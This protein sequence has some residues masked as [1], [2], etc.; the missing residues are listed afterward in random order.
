MTSLPPFLLNDGTTLPAVGFGTWRVRGDEAVAQVRSA[1]DA[2]YRLIDTAAS[3]GNEAEVGRAVTGTDVPRSEIA[4]A[5]KLRGADQGYDATLRGFEATRTALGL[6]YLDLYLIHWPLPR[7]GKFVESW[8]ALVRLR[9]DGLIR[10]VG[11]SNFT[12]AHLDRLIDETGEVPAVNQIE[13]HPGFVQEDMRAANADRGILTQSWG[14][15]GRGKGLLERPEIARIAAARGVSPAQA[16]LRWHH[17]LGVQPLPKSAD[18]ARQQENLDLTGF[19][20]TDEEMARIASVPQERLGG[21]PDT[22]EE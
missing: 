3:Y 12:A 5:S 15:L 4:V 11:V 9:E 10:T 22:H 8:K 16:V 1:L 14:P 19:S 18:P 21:D 13:L 17:Q 6:E 7:L 20:L 2:G